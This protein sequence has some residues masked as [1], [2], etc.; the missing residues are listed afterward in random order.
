MA[1]S[2][3]LRSVDVI[4]LLSSSGY[5]L[6]SGRSGP[7]GTILRVRVPTCWMFA[8]VDVGKAFAHVP[9]GAKGLG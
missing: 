3:V 8:R 5:P 2:A 6:T 9:S 1:M 7:V 4:R